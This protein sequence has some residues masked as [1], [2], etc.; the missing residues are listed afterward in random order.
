[1]IREII[2]EQDMSIVVFNMLPTSVQSR[3][4]ALQSLRRSTS[5]SILSSRRPPIPP[6]K[7][8]DPVMIASEDESSVVE[9][10][11]CTV[12]STAAT[13]YE[14]KQKSSGPDICSSGVSSGVKWRYAA[15]GTY[16][17][18]S[19]S[20]ET[21][22]SAFAR[23]SYIDGVAYMLRALPDDLDDYETNI[24][25]QALPESCAQVEMHNQIEGGLNK[26][27]W[28]PSD[29]A[30]SILHSSVQGFVT[31]LVLLGYIILS[32]LA[33]VIRVGA[34]YERQY[35]ISQHIVTSGFGFATAIG[36]QSGAL[37]EKFSAFSEGKIGKVLTD[38]TAWALE[39][40][41]AGVQDGIG[42]GLIL[43]EQRRK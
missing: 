25:R 42:Q 18:H 2:M 6:R 19:A 7:E 30:R 20:Q 37:S 40:V 43:I 26:S 29:R 14:D 15:Q 39:N 9:L 31:V 5:F 24:I 34:H 35:N 28:Q 11:A 16:L 12:A 38:L 10:Q 36:K 21:V 4:P 23:K 32:F 27:G 1:M 41:A 17:Q 22:D 3:L 13:R 33:A 8:V